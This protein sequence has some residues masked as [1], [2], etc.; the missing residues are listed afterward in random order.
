MK[1]PHD[2]DEVIAVVNDRDEVIGEATRKE[3][4][5]KGLLHRE[6]CVYLI[7]SE[8]RVLL[9]KR[10][11]RHIWDSSA[12]G[13][14]PINQNYEEAVQREFKEELGLELDQNKFKEIGYERLKVNVKNKGLINY[15]FSK[16]F[17]VRKDIPIE[18]FKIDK[19]EI[20]EIRY[21]DRKELE[22]LLKGPYLMTRSNEIFIKKYILKEL[23]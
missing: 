6:A 17:L 5:E 8:N 7:N 19:E 10:T 21:F 11:D 4:H 16:I 22:K 18:D 23:K 14:F 9:Q 20:E 13:H 3:V 2:P 12:A 1:V 15:K